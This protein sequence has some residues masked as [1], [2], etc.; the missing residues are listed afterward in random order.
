[1][2][3]ISLLTAHEAEEPTSPYICIKLLTLITLNSHPHACHL[4]HVHVHVHV[5]AWGHTHEDTM[6]G[7]II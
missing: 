2:T 4:I 5:W 7:F 1:M 3:M 6:C